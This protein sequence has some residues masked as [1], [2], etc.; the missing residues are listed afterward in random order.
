M[1]IHVLAPSGTFVPADLDTDFLLVA[2]GSGITPMM[3]ICKSA[4]AQGSGQ[5]TLIYA[6]RDEKSVIFAA[7]L[8]DLAARYPDRFSVVHWLESVQGLPARPHWPPG[9]AAH[10]PAGVHLRARS[11]HD[12][13]VGGPRPRSAYR[14]SRC[15]SRCSSRW[16]PIRSRRSPPT[17]RR[18][19][20][21]R[22][23][24]HRGGHPRRH[25]H[26]PL[27]WP[28]KAKLLD[29]LLDKGLE[30]PFSCR[31]GHC[32]ACAVV[33]QERL[34]GHGDQRRARAVRPRRGSD[35]GLPGTPP[36]IP[37]K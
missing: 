15:T 17:T 8:W 31:E 33:P 30:A 4:L 23:A 37:S 7:A 10:R 16:S 27:T 11:V 13:R 12:G 26:E 21:R 5:V 34:G 1:K 28:R 32:G 6:N 24:G 35:P 29:V 14:P 9:G 20:R 19:G 36:P 18:G 25:H 2:G 22:G 3:A